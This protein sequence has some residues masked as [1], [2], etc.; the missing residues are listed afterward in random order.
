MKR[1]VLAGVV[2]LGGLSGP[3]FAADVAPVFVP[4]PV[5]PPPAPV[6]DL[7]APS[8]YVELFGEAAWNEYDDVYNPWI[9]FGGA[10]RANVWH[11]TNFSTQWDAAGDFVYETDEEYYW[12]GSLNLTGHASWRNPSSHLIGGFVTLSHMV[13]DGYIAMGSIAGG[14]EGQMYLGNLTLYGL[15]GWAHQLWGTYGGSCSTCDPS[16]R[17]SV[18]FA[19]GAARFFIGDNTK[20]EAGIGVIS[21]DIEGSNYDVT[22]LTWDAEIEH[23]FDMSPL[24][25]FLAGSGHTTSDTDFGDT[26]RIM[27]GAKIHLGQDTL[28]QQDRYG[29]T[30]EGFD[31]THM[32]WLRL[33]N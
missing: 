21:G 15:A 10:G 13:D 19:R 30:L 24:S 20:I 4:P 25:I 23:K 16:Y 11:G 27:A 14:I 32:S 17:M 28:L 1:I 26:Q 6:R 12:V 33:W 9:G 18:G 31:M 5:A 2:A 22:A 3:A 29:A 7:Y 8:G